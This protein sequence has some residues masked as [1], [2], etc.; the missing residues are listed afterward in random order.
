MRSSTSSMPDRQPDQVGGHL[1]LGARDRGVRHAGRVLDEGLDAAERLAERPDLGLAA[2]LDRDVLA[3][4]DLERDHPAEP[5]HLA[6]GDLVAGVALAGPGSA[7]HSRPGGSGGTRRPARRC[8]CAAPCAAASVLRPR[9]TSQASNGPATAPIEFWWKAT[10]STASSK[11]CTVMSSAHDDR[12]ADDVGVAA[13]VLRGRVRDDVGAERERLLQVGRGEGVVDD[14][15]GARRRA[16][17]RRGRR[18]RRCRAAGWWASRPRR[19]WSAP[20][21]SPRGPRRRRPSGRWCARRPTGPA[22]C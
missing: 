1:E 20:G 18:C 15:Q 8:R 22:P 19:S 14:E 2:D 17:R 4:L 16:R 6:L 12:A 13:A 3:G 5:L 11:P 9:R 7:P 10:R 21:G